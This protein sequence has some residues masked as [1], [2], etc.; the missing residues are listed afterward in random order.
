MSVFVT[1]VLFGSIAAMQLSRAGTGL[2][3]PSLPRRSEIVAK[4][5][6]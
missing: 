6:L 1:H 2:A 3:R 5:G 4:A